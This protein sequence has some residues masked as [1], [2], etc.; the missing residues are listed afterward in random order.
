MPDTNISSVSVTLR[1]VDAKPINESVGFKFYNQRAASLN[2]LVPTTF[3]VWDG[4]K[5][6][7]IPAFP[8]GLYEVFIDPAKH[9]FKNI[10]L[11]VQADGSSRMEETFFVDPSKVAPIFPA[12]ADLQTGVRWKELWRVLTASG[13]G[14][15]AD[16][17]RLSDQQRAGLFNLYAKMTREKVADDQPVFRSVSRIDEFLP[18]RVLA[19]VSADLFEAVGTNHRTFRSVPG[20]L[21]EFP[22]GW[23]PAA[24]DNSFKTFDAAGNL[25]LTFATN[26]AGEFLA[27]IDI[28][29][30]RGIEH[31]GDVLKHV[32]TGKDTHPYDIHEILIFFQGLDPGY[33][34]V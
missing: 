17:N 5:L 11:S 4:V 30:H 15:E 23:R 32:I 9:R 24:E 29:D 14:T 19:R 33:Q 10:F 18:A 31:A 1:G 2:R 27:D 20:A 3:R 26:P 6:D 8:F 34:L 22:L 21:H 28:D 13:R 16:W 25:Q 12:L 7:G